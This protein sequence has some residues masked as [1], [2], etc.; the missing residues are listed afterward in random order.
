[1]AIDIG[2]WLDKKTGISQLFWHAN[3]VRL[4]I[5]HQVPF[6]SRHST[7]RVK[8]EAIGERQDWGPPFT[9]LY[10]TGASQVIPISTSLEEQ[11][12]LLQK[13]KTE[14]LS[15]YPSNLRGLLELWR[16]S[17]T[18][19]AEL[20]WIKCN[21][22]TLPEDVRQ[23]VAELYSGVSVID[24]YFSQ[25]FGAIALQCPDGGPDGGPDRG[26]HVMSESLLVETLD[27]HDS[28]CSPGQ[29][30]RVVITDLHNLAAPLI[31]YDI[32]DYAELGEPCSCGRGSHKLKRILGRTR[33]LIVKPNGDRHW[34][35]TGY[36]E[37]SSI[38]P[39]RQYQMV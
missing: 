19:L 18:R 36:R 11:V 30:G 17:D 21:S 14:T 33:N 3:T 34:P 4:H 6:S 8:I 15:I 29:T 27:Q 16:D 20:K 35:L 25:E 10:R 23:D 28:P 1:M 9:H 7:I 32:G 13:F 31:R 38:V 26:L 37:C 2:R 22:E 12:E 24:G 39:F 5:W